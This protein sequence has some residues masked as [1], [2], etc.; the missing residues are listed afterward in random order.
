MS[1]LL[2]ATPGQQ[3]VNQLLAILVTLLLASVGGLITGEDRRLEV[4][5]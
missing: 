1:E 2:L 4:R 5:N 3:A